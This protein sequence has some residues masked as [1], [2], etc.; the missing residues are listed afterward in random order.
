MGKW[1][2]GSMVLIN[3]QEVYAWES[4]RRRKGGEVEEE[5]EEVEEER[6]RSRN[7]TF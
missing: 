6:K 4:A 5:E 1:T 7:V 2:Y 3:V